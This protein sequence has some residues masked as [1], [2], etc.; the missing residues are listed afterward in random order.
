MGSLLALSA[1]AFRFS[2]IAWTSSS[3]LISSGLDFSVCSD[4]SVQFPELRLGDCGCHHI[5][6]ALGLRS[7]RVGFCQLRSEAFG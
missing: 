3:V 7:D 2:R 5:H 6:W 4:L 1:I